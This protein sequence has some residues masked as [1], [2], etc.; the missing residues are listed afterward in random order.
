MKWLRRVAMLATLG[1]VSFGTSGCHVDAYNVCLFTRE[2][3]DDKIIWSA[4]GHDS[5]VTQYDHYRC[6]SRNFL[7]SENPIKVWCVYEVPLGD[8]SIGFAKLSNCWW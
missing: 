2:T 7:V 3:P 1:F 6:V 8:G 5:S 4:W